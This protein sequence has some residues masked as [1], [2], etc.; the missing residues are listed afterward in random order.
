MFGGTGVQGNDVGWLSDLWSCTLTASGGSAHCRRHGGA[1][2]LKVNAGARFAGLGVPTASAWPGA[3]YGHV[4]WQEQQAPPYASA[5]E[6]ESAAD[7]AARE[8]PEARQSPTARAVGH[9]S[10]AR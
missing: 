10:R 6:S 7:R 2:L 1:A 9:R 4:M 8:A 5:N 3:Q